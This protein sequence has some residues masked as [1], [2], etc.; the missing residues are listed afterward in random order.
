[1]KL[2][3]VQFIRKVAH[4]AKLGEG[5][6]PGEVCLLLTITHDLI[7]EVERLNKQLGSPYDLTVVEAQLESSRQFV[8]SLQ[9]ELK[10]A[11]RFLF[12]NTTVKQLRSDLVIL[13]EE[14]DRLQ[15][16]LDEAKGKVRKG[17]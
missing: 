1:M 14:N 7:E 4:H 3:E 2:E 13:R 6:L 16:A 9:A 12:D 11:K 8:E 15:A 10:E 5:L 17:K